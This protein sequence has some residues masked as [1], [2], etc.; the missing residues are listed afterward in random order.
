MYLAKKELHVVLWKLHVASK[1]FLKLEKIGLNL[2][3]GPL[4][5]NFLMYN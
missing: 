1:I 2:E 4:E 5:I 3:K